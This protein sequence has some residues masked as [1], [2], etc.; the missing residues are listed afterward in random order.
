M[1]ESRVLRRIF[2]PKRDE[3]MGEW[4]M[5]YNVEVH[6]LY[7]SPNIIRQ[8]RSRRMP[9]A[10]HVVRMGEERKLYKVLVEKPE[11]KNYSED[12]A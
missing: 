7:L 8:I 11:G 6:K 1:F 2:V 12:Q 10:V 5:L 9:W 3:V 4:R